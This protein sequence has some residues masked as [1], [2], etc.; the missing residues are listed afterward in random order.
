VQDGAIWFAIP[1]VTVRVIG[2]LLYF[3]VAW[4]DPLQRRAVRIFAAFSITGLIAVLL[5]A[6]QGGQA[7][8]WWWGAAIALDPLAAHIGGQLEGWNLHPEHFV[9]RHGLIVIIALG[10]TLIVAAAGLI[11]AP[12]TPT[13]IVTS[14]LAVAVTC[15]LWWSYFARARHTFERILTEQKDSLRSRAAR[16]IFSVI[17]FPMLCGVL[18]IAAVV[19][20]AL[21]HPDQSLTLSSR[22]ALGTGITLFVCG[23]AVALWRGT[24]KTSSPRWVLAPMA[25]IAIILLGAT[26]WIALLIGLGMLSL[27]GVVEHR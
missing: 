10:E 18:A 9:E 5:G 2:L 7:L 12:R 24:G 27:L 21:A 1:Y 20:Q 11:G 16:V 25:A 4:G 26:P 8:Y 3:W 14:V 22:I 23:T 6:I 19:E 13:V 17:H 15:G